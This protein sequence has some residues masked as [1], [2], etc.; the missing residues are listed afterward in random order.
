MKPIVNGDFGGY[1]ESSPVG[2][3]KAK[4][5]ISERRACIPVGIDRPTFRY[6]PQTTNP[7]QPW[8]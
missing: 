8:V 7:L 2:A 4:T 3:M 5:K 1:P 6:Q